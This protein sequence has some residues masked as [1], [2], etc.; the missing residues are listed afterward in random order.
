MSD[1]LVIPL[2][3]VELNQIRKQKPGVTTD[4]IVENRIDMSTQVKGMFQELLDKVEE[5]NKNIPAPLGDVANKAEM[6]WQNMYHYLKNEL[7]WRIDRGHE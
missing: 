6:D 2:P 7:K 3:S 5:L 1:E 4:K